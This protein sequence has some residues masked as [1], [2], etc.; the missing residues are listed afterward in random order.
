MNI[1]LRPP[2]IL[3]TLFRVIIHNSLPSQNLHP[4]PEQRE[5]LDQG[6][7]FQTTCKGP[8]GNANGTDKSGEADLIFQKYLRFVKRWPG[9]YQVRWEDIEFHC[10]DQASHHQE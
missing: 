9:L 8:C 6:T 7:A 1:S 2:R 5:V 10:Q 4:A 3:W